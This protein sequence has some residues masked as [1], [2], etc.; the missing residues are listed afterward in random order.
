VQSAAY[1]LDELGWLQFERLC[2]LVLAEEAGLADLTWLGRADRGR[3]AML[4]AGV[5]LPAAGIRLRGPLAVAVVWV[6][7]SPSDMER[8]G[9]L[10]A[11][12]SSVPSELG[13]W[14][15]RMSSACAT[16]RR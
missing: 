12:V 8:A 6:R 13:G 11:G 10:F 16:W 3:V 14:F 5:S 1:R 4:D 2:G 15:D 9:D 7:S